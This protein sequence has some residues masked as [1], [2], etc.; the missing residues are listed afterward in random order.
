MKEQSSSFFLSIKEGIVKNYSF[1]AA[2]QGKVYISTQRLRFD[3][4]RNASP[5]FNVYQLQLNL[6]SKCVVSIIFTY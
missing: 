3:D 4:V 5:S 2:S 1:Y 6:H